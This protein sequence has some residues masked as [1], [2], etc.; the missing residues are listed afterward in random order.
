MMAPRA[1]RPT[2]AVE[3]SSPRAAAG[4]SEQFMT[5]TSPGRRLVEKIN[6]RTIVTPRRLLDR[7]APCRP[8]PANDDPLAGKRND[9]GL[10]GLIPV[11][12]P[13]AD[14]RKHRAV[15]K[16][17]QPVEID[18]RVCERVDIDHD[19]SLFRISGFDLSSV[20]P[21]ARKTRAQL[22]A[23]ENNECR[24][25][26]PPGSSTGGRRNQRPCWQRSNGRWRSPPRRRSR[27]LTFFALPA[28]CL[29][30]FH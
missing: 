23:G 13:I 5:G 4:L 10:G 28:L 7:P 27:G 22:Q 9:A 1:P 15:G 29:G 6:F 16:L 30:S 14:I 12:K 18:I 3:N 17:G 11:A 2:E 21:R 26:T 19:R 25:R 8:R 24:M 20:R